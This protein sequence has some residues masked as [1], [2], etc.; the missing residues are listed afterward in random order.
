ML[1]EDNAYLLL[2]PVL[3]PATQKSQIN[4]NFKYLSLKL[5]FHKISK[6]LQPTGEVNSKMAPVQVANVS[7]PK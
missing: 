7:K 1:I 3:I 5:I 2:S 6:L 4:G